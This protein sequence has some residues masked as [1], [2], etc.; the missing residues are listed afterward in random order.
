LGGIAID[1][2][3]DAV[4]IGIAEVEGFADTVVGGTVERDVVF[5]ET[6]QG[7]CQRGA[8]GVENGDVKETCG[9]ARRGFATA[10]FPGVEADVMMVSTRRDEGGLGAVALG[11]LETED[12]AVEGEG[13]LQV[14]HLEV[15]V[16]DA[17]GGV[18]GGAHIKQR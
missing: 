10:A 2:E 14:G 6:A 3:L 7:V 12:A 9:A 17:D 15:D 8:V 1:V 4:V 13:A 11:E 5:D 16:A 18:D